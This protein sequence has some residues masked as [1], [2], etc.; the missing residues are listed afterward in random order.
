LAAR[1]VF[2]LRRIAMYFWLA[3]PAAAAIETET[4][5][6]RPD[7]STEIRQQILMNMEAS[8]VASSD[9]K[10]ALMNYVIAGGGPTGVEVAGALTELGR[11]VA[12][13]GC[14]RHHRNAGTLHNRLHRR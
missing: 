14:E 13:G 10:D 2:W 12:P 11:G 3:P 4:W 9:E 6:D 7:G 5:V 1:P 8:L